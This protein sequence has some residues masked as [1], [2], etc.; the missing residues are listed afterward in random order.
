LGVYRS[1]AE[2]SHVSKS[3]YAIAAIGGLGCLALSLMM[4][5]LLE[6][7]QERERPP[8]VAELESF[9]A[10]QLT[11]PIGY[12][13]RQEGGRSTIILQMVVTADT[14]TAN[15]AFARSASDLV[16]RLGGRYLRELPDEL[17]IEVGTDAA[18]VGDA[19]PYVHRCL[20]PGTSAPKVHVSRPAAPSA[21]SGR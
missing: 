21:G 5:H 16:W 20:R 6:T 9:L 17:V 12:R 13:Y 14:A 2:R 1:D 3:I 18:P 19:D 8:I 11:G 10:D 4:Q 15:A 7:Q